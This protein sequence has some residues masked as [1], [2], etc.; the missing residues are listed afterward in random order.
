MEKYKTPD[1]QLVCFAIAAQEEGS[2]SDQTQELKATTG[3][4]LSNLYSYTHNTVQHL[5]VSE[6]SLGEKGWQSE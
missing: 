2:V 1:N 3:V 5:Q 6:V 4:C